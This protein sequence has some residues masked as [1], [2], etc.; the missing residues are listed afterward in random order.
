MSTARSSLQAE[1]LHQ[2]ESSEKSSAVKDKDPSKQVGDH[3]L[4]TENQLVTDSNGNN[5]KPE[6]DVYAVDDEKYIAGMEKFNKL[7]W[8]QLTIVSNNNKQLILHFR[9]IKRRIRTQ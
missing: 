1:T 3:D 4:T 2:N 8:K 9:G 7:T 6:T 5:P